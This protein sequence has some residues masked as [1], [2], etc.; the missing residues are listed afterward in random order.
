MDA[1]SSNQ[2]PTADHVGQEARFG[3]RNLSLI[4]I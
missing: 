2:N 4:H 3:A 1:S